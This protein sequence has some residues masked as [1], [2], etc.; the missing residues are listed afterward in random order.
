MAPMTRWVT[1]FALRLA[2]QQGIRL[3]KPGETRPP[4]Y[5]MGNHWTGRPFVSSDDAV[6]PA[7]PDPKAARRDA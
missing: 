5:Y 6:V 3:L 2:R 7:D 1:E 4:N